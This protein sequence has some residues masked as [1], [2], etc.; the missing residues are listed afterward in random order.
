[1][2]QNRLY[3]AALGLSFWL[4]MAFFY[5]VSANPVL[6]A[7]CYFQS[8][9]DNSWENAANWNCGTIPTAEDN[10][11]INATSTYL[12]AESYVNTI[13]MD[14]TGLLYLGGYTLH[15]KGD[16]LGIDGGVADQGTVIL[17]GTAPQGITQ[18]LGNNFDN[19]TIN[20]SGA[21]VQNNNPITVDGIFD[22]ESSLVSFDD[23]TLNA[24]STIAAA[25][26]ISSAGDLKFYGDVINLGNIATLVNTVVWFMSSTTNYGIIDPASGELLI[27]GTFG[28]YGTIN[29]SDGTIKFNDSVA[30]PQGTFNPESST[31]IVMGSDSLG[32]PF[33]QYNNLTISKTAGTITMT[34]DATTTGDFSMVLEGEGATQVLA[35][36]GYT[37]DVGGNLS[38]ASGNLTTGTGGKLYLAGNWDD[39][40]DGFNGMGGT[41][42]F[43]GSVEQAVSGEDGFGDVTA[44]NFMRFTA[45]STI[46]ENLLVV[47]DM[48]VYTNPGV[49][50]TVSGT[51]DIETGGALWNSGGVLDLNGQVTNNGSLG[52]DTDGN[53][54][55]HAGLLN[56]AGSAF[57]IG[58]GTSHYIMGTWD[59]RGDY[60]G[61]TG[62]LSLYG[63]FINTGT[64]NAGTGTT[65][66]MTTDG[67]S[68]DIDGV[69]FSSLHIARAGGQETGGT[70]VLTGSDATA[71]NIWAE[72][73]VFS[74]SSLNLTVTSTSR[75]SSGATVTSTSGDISLASLNNGGELGTISGNMLFDNIQNGGTLDIGSGTATTTALTG[76]GTINGGS[77]TL[78]IAGTLGG[79][80]T[81]N[82]GTGTVKYSNAA[83]QDV[84]GAYEYNNLIIDNAGGTATLDSDA[85]STGS[86]AVRA[87]GAFDLDGNVFAASGESYSNLGVISLNEG[88]IVHEN[89]GV[90]VTNNSGVSVASIT[91]PGS[92]YVT[93]T[94][95]DSNL[96][97]T[98]ANTITVTIQAS[99]Q[100]GS[101]SETL[102]LTETGVATG[103]FRNA[104]ALAVTNATIAVGDGT[105][106]ISGN[107]VG[108]ASFT[109][110]NDST[111]T[112]SDTVN[113]TY[114]APDPPAPEPTPSSGGGGTYYNLP[115]VTTYQTSQNRL[116]DPDRQKNLEGLGKLNLNVN[117]LVKLEDDGDSNTQE[118]SAVY[119]IGADGKRHAFPTSKIYFTWYSDFSAVK[120]I[121]LENMAQI[122]LGKSVRYK[123]GS[124]M[125]K[126]TTVPDTYLVLSGGI[127]RW[128]KT[129]EVAKALYGSG[130]NMFIDDLSDAMFTSY[131]VGEPI[132][133]ATEV[134]LETVK[135][136]SL[137]ISD[138]LHL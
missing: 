12:G 49:T 44:L 45:D 96:N 72:Y 93:V 25:G 29:G 11:F 118:D 131:S 86:F 64:F 41:V 35:I 70:V 133:S 10:V 73:G 2:F 114:V 56:N 119:Y 42:Y 53:M 115:V 130:W 84:I 106:E 90:A 33:N 40:A 111:D 61:E 108:T 77:G 5:A 137:T 123:P 127:L 69:A 125:L 39:I 19:L 58:S 27:E 54:Y 55:F 1:M 76:T 48:G 51:T 128:V 9:V 87:G 38:I 94:D 16:W 101:D 78:V 63:D 60:F 98:I 4:L 50:L 13:R 32:L 83:G 95:K 120:V 100:A 68:Q 7:D 34:E 134:N 65:T 28:N 30:S 99:A 43:N 23:I 135:T 103:V 20:N 74:L 92:L 80:L 17:D 62:I 14:S 31:V 15:V 88:S 37:L 36:D 107:G 105:L 46:G 124:R 18:N 82:K 22:L 102:T 66:I 21:D 75:I 113:L 112:G 79:D 6:A 110:A 57:M 132:N 8:T 59:N 52:S 121:S 138:D 47:A 3:K 109:N 126:F 89:D 24:T 26:V 136:S 122:P 104:S 71:V 81:F 91:T 129:E 116:P 67:A 117:A 85:T 97:G